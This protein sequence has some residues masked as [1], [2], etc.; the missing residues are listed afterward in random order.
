MWLSTG[1]TADYTNW[2]PGQP[3]NPV[4]LCVELVQ[5]RN[6]GLFWNDLGCEV[7][8][9]FIC[10]SYQNIIITPRVSES[11]AEPKPTAAKLDTIIGKSLFNQVIVI[12]FY[13]E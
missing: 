2:L 10:E 11:V 1:R 5:K 8:L 7:P 6:E 9:S 12:I 4:E 3:D 13:I